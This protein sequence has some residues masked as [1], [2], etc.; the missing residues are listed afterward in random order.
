MHSRLLLVQGR[1]LLLLLIVITALFETTESL[2][3]RPVV[4]PPSATAENRI[5]DYEEV[6]ATSSPS[7]AIST[8]TETTS[9]VAMSSIA[10]ED[11]YLVNDPL[12]EMPLLPITS[13]ATVR[14]CRAMKTSSRDVFVCS[15]PKSGTTW[16]QNIV[17]RL[18]W[19]I[20]SGNSD[21]PLPE[22]WHLSHSA[23]FYEVDQYWRRSQKDS[24]STNDNHDEEES[25]ERLAAQ[26][27]IRNENEYRVFNTH[28]LPHQLPKNAKC[29]YVVRDPLD[30]MVSFYHH[31]SNQAVEDGGFTG[32]FEEF[33]EG[34]LEGTIVY[35]KWQDHIEAWL[36]NGV[37]VDGTDK[38]RNFLLLHYEDMKEDLARETKRLVKF[39]SDEDDESSEDRYLDELVSRVVPQCTF[40]AMKRERKRYTPLT[41]SWKVN[42]KTGK[43]Y[44]E[45]VRKGTIGDGRKLV[46]ET[47]SSSSS[48]LKD[49]WTDQDT[50]I[51]KARWNNAGV[52]QDIIDRYL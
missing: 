52:E 33:F 9:F 50:P 12:P 15:Y 11:S 22:D 44:D 45:F 34:F 14:A 28:L 2:S 35:G 40:D 29:V 43:P 7:T 37:V 51:A 19:E 39:L 18:L 26:T 1:L 48:A 46:L 16:T 20:A 5:S 41:V 8:Q 13:E 21:H 27:P 25:M 4:A 24:K 36:G 49:R 3:D 23:P 10:P 47:P 42:P 30:V 32:T 17:V 31:L 38:E 6:E